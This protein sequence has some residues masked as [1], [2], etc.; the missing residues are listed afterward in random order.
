ML[1]SILLASAVVFAAPT[2]A[3]D[4]QDQ[5]PP[6]QEQPAPDM[7]DPAPEPMPT[8]EPTPTPEPAPETE[9]EMAPEPTPEPVPEPQTA[10]MTQTSATTSTAGQQPATAEQIAQVVDTGFPTYDKDADGNLKPEEFGEWMVALRSATEPAF[11]GE[12]TADQQW[13]GQALA[14]ADTDQS[15]TVSKDELKAFLAPQ[16]S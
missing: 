10:Q 5:Q 13:I 8:P 16:A 14:A 1:K 4:V 12:S 3:Q 7:T 15:G 6:V 11:T 2:L 9:D